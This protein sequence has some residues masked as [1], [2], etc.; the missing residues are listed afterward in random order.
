MDI[1]YAYPDPTMQ[2]AMRLISHIT[3]DFEALV[4]TTFAHN[5]SNGAI[6]RLYI[7]RACG[8]YQADKLT[9][10]VSVIDATNFL[11]D[12]DTMEFDA[13]IDPPVVPPPPPPVIPIPNP[14]IPTCAFVVPVGEISS[15]LDSTVSNVLPYP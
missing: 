10:Q 12:I 13:F 11:L 8:M 5:Y 3:N 2:P 4:T 7:P 9:G 15:T 14:H 6:V 1:G